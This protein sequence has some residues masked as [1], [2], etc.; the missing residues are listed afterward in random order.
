MTTTLQAAPDGAPMTTC[1][2]CGQPVARNPVGRPARYCNQTCK[3]TFENRERSRWAAIGRE[4][5]R[6]VLARQGEAR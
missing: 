2:A 6:I 4:A 5:E 3:R 1:P